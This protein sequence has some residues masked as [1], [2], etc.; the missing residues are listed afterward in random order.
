MYKSIVTFSILLPLA[1]FG[2]YCPNVGRWTTRDPIEGKDGANLY[3]FCKNDS[4]GK[5][6]PLGQDVY[7]M[8]AGEEGDSSVARRLIVLA[9]SAGRSV[10]V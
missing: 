1:A 8:N 9:L 5:V 6:D 4:V 10:P 3:A 7:L 2:Y